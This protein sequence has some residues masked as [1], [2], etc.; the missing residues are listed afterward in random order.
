MKHKSPFVALVLISSFLLINSVSSQDLVVIVNSGNATATLSK[1][2]CKNIF[3]GKK[4]TWSNGSPIAFVEPKANSDLKKG[5]N[6]DFLGM[7]TPDVQKYWVRET[8]RGNLPL[9]QTVASPEEIIAYVSAN[10]NAI[11]YLAK[12]DVPTSGKVKAITVN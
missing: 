8:I 4:T 3:L 1:Q 10:K 2:D 12:A 5:F 11:G 6:T 7:T 9:P